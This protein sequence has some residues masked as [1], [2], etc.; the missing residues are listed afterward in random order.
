MHESILRKDNV[1]N[2][3]EITN[4]AHNSLILAN[5]LKAWQSCSSAILWTQQ[6]SARCLEQLFYNLALL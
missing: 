2:H 4:T 6:A 1:I 5:V 3:F